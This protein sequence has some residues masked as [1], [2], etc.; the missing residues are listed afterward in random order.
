MKKKHITQKQTF[1]K[2]INLNDPSIRIRGAALYQPKT[3]NE[4][5]SLFSQF[6]DLRVF[7][8]ESNQLP[9]FQS[10]WYITGRK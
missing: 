9:I 10:W 2:N 6:K 7:L 3:E 5:K 4:L 8:T 1:I